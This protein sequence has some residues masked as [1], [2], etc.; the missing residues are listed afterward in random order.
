MDTDLQ[1]FAHA[2]IS[3]LEIR[4]FSSVKSIK[5]TLLR[6]GPNKK[7]KTEK[8]ADF[9]A[10]MRFVLQACLQDEIYVFLSGLRKQ[11][12]AFVSL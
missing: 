12:R 8:T 10:L 7:T 6:L 2:N 3:K 5:N 1:G 9:A 11:G 4:C